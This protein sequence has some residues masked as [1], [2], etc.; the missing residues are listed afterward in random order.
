[1]TI[2]KYTKHLENRLKLRKIKH[3]LPRKI[4]VEAKDRY[5]DE[6][7]GH[8]IAVIEAELYDKMKEVMV[9]YTI[10]ND[11]VNLITV[12]PLKAGQKDNRIQTRR[13]RKI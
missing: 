12:H 13:W 7:T 5:Y 4:F 2:L 10:E 9:A 11:V 3:D 8:Y 1:M 6:E